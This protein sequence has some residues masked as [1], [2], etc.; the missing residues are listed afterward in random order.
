MSEDNE[1]SR[2]GLAYSRRAPSD[3]DGLI[4]RTIIIRLFSFLF[5]CFWLLFYA[6]WTFDDEPVF[7]VSAL[8]KGESD[9]QQFNFMRRWLW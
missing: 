4:G 9:V 8:Q 6:D 5:V 3:A 7:M 1:L 2:K